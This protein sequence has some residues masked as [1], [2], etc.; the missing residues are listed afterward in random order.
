MID[1]PAPHTSHK[2]KPGTT[3][4]SSKLIG[5]VFGA[6]L[7]GGGSFA[8]GLQYQKSKQ[9]GASTSTVGQTAQSST[10]GNAGGYGA[11]GMR[12][13]R[14]RPNLGQV[15]A[16]N[17]SSITVKNSQT[18]ASTTFSITS[19]TTITDNGQT[20]STSDIQVGDTV[21]VVASTANATQA[22]R[23]LVNPNFGGTPSSSSGSSTPSTIMT[24]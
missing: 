24:N 22:Q 20:A 5:L 11:S 10:N 6:L 12:S 15:T 14:Q 3:L 23:I 18:S 17:A 1:E 13:G 2:H 21:G 8:A 19:S 16:I 4:Q 7:L 9:P